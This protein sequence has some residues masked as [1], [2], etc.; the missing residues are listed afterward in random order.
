VN[1]VPDFRAVRL[2]EAVRQADEWLGDAR[3]ASWVAATNAQ[4]EADQFAF[5]A[6]SVTLHGVTLIPR[7]SWVNLTVAQPA[8]NPKPRRRLNCL[9][10]K[11]QVNRGWTGEGIIVLVF[12]I[13]GGT[14]GNIY[15]KP[16]HIVRD[17]ITD[18]EPTQPTSQM[19]EREAE[20]EKRGW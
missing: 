15:F 18:I 13:Y 20:V 5:E 17:H 7:E 10:I 14:K 16:D 2:D 4:R 11:Q 19:L 8:I 3:L 6:A 9:F 12:H 1:E